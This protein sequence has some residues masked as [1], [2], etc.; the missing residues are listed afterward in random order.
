MSLAWGTQR[1]SPFNA[2]ILLA[3]FASLAGWIAIGLL[4]WVGVGKIV[5]IILEA[6]R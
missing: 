3:V 6:L 1:K 2:G 5:H 4:V